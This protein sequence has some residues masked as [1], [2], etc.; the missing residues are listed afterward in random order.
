[1]LCKIQLVLLA[2]ALSMSLAAADAF[3]PTWAVGDS[4]RVHVKRYQEN[5]EG[6][7][8]SERDFREFV[9]VYEVIDTE[10]ISGRA[11]LKLRISVNALATVVIVRIDQE[12]RY[13]VDYEVVGEP[14][15]KQAGEKRSA[16]GDSMVGG[17]PGSFNFLLD[18]PVF[19]IPNA[20]EDRVVVAP[21]ASA[22][23]GLRQKIIFTPMT[24]EVTWTSSE[25]DDT[26][27][28]HSQLW[29]IGDKWPET[30]WKKVPSESGP[31][32]DQIIET[33]VR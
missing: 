26:V 30:S 9:K 28:V 18:F 21:E 7:V 14:G 22:E 1:M 15:I 10:M 23:S 32:E 8:T 31:L 3:P 25:G 16:P 33:L 4:W 29:R 12:R 24:A 6:R 13:I 2:T 20:N 27:A 11:T 17:I 5:I 19:P